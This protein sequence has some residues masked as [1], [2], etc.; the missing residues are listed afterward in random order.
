M[1]YCVGCGKEMHETA[2]FCP[3]CGAVN[4]SNQTSEVRTL[5]GH[6]WGIILITIFWFLLWVASFT[7]ENGDVVNYDDFDGIIA[8]FILNGIF[9]VP[10]IIW[11]LL[12]EQSNKLLPIIGSLLYG[13]HFLIVLGVG[14]NL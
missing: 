2:A 14:M 3:S 9:V 10:W 11:V 8:I 5:I 12:K 6:G 4:P 7:D 1:I 13:F